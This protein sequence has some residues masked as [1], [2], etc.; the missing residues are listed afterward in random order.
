MI[1]LRPQ[2]KTKGTRITGVPFFMR[3]NSPEFPGLRQ[4]DWFSE[5]G[6]ASDCSSTQIALAQ[7]SSRCG[8][9]QRWRFAHSGLG[10]PQV[11][12]SI[13]SC[14]PPGTLT[15]DAAGPV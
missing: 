14:A 1:S 2:T 15:K 9:R 6:F 8:A 10:W 7:A 4:C 5:R 3:H 11:F 13:G 12:E